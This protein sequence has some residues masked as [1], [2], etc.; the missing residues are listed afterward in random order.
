[1]IKT[2]D[3]N[4]LDLDVSITIRFLSSYSWCFSFINLVFS[5]LWCIFIFM[6]V[7]NV[8]IMHDM[9]LHWFRAFF[10][11]YS[12]SRCTYHDILL[13]IFV[14][15]M[16]PSWYASPHTLDLVEIMVPHIFDLDVS[17][18]IRFLSSYSWCFAF[19]LVFSGLMMH[20]IFIFALNVEI[21]AHDMLLHWLRLR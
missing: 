4:I 3:A 1:M 20:I 5:G 18:T 14:I 10:S 2:N 11:S 21:M 16:C 13:L 7:L 9:L 6:F 8:E 19:N 17:I 12:W 15:L